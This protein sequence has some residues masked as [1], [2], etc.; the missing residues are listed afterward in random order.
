MLPTN[1]TCHLIVVSVFHTEHFLD[2]PASDD[3]K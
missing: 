1:K 3:M 2:R